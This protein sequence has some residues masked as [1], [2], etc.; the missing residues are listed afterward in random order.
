[1]QV[2]NRPLTSVAH[3]DPRW[4]SVRVETNRSRVGRDGTVYP[5]I[6]YERN[7]LTFARQSETTLAD[8][9]ADPVTG[10]IEVRIGWG[11]LHVMDPSS[12][13][14]LHGTQEDGRSPGG[15]ATAGFGFVIQSYDP[16]SP[17]AGGA[18]LGC[19]APLRW[20]W[21]PWEEP[22]GWHEEVKPLFGTMR[23]TFRTITGPA[24]AALSSPG[25]TRSP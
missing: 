25:S 7:R 4:D 19:G 23:D 13:W 20:S 1:M 12:R 21:E 18:L 8:W 14:V 5:A 2:Y 11:L 10:T 16:Q 6:T 24:G 22:P 9:Y 17:G 3:D 15:I